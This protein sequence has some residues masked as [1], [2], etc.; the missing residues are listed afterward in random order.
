[1]ELNWVT[2]SAIGGGIA[3]LLIIVSLFRNGKRGWGWVFAG[4]VIVFALAIFSTFVSIFRILGNASYRRSGWW[5]G[6]GGSWSGG[7]S[8]ASFRGSGGGTSGG[9]GFSAGGGASGSW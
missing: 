2:A 9:G 4:A 8:R 1:M 6:M 5:S 7:G 3:L